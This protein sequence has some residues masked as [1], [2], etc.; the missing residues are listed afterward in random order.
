[1]RHFQPKQYFAAAHRAVVN[2]EAIEW[3]ELPSLAERLV[4]R[5]P[6]P[7]RGANDSAFDAASSHGAWDATLP[8]ALD[9]ALQS[10]LFREP[11]QGLSTREVTEPDVFRHFFGAAAE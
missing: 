3:E 6:G 7:P 8:A 5:S 4:N 2:S 10:A 11:L 9:P 1:M